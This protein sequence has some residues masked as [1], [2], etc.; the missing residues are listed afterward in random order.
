MLLAEYGP[1]WVFLRRLHL[2]LNSGLD[3]GGGADH[4]ERKIMGWPFFERVPSPRG[5]WRWR[6]SG[7]KTS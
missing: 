2:G 5:D 6:S 3:N 1:P 4:K 7:S